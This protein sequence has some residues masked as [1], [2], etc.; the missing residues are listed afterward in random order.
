MTL[1]DLGLAPIDVLDLIADEGGAGLAELDDR[2]RAPG[3]RHR[4]PRARRRGSRS[5]TWTAGPGQTQRLRGLGAGE[6]AAR[7]WR[8]SRVRCG[9]ATSACR[10]RRR[11]RT[12]CP[13]WWRAAASPTWST[14]SRPCATD[15]DAAIA[16]GAAAARRP[17]HEPRRR[18]SPASTIGIATVVER[19]A[20]T[21]RRSA[22]PGSDGARLYDWRAERFATCSTRIADLLDRWDGRLAACDAALADELRCPARPRP[23]STSA[24]A[25]RR[26]PGLDELPPTPIRSARARPAARDAPRR[27][28]AKRTRRPRTARRRRQSRPCRPAG[29]LR[30]ASCRSPPSTPSRSP[31]PTSR[32]R[33]R[34]LGGPAVAARLGARRRRQADRRGATGADGARCRARPARRAS[35]ALQPAAEA[36]FGEGFTLIPT[37]TLPAAAGAEQT[38][39]HAA[40]HLAAPCSRTPAPRSDDDNP[41]D[42]WFYG[43]ARV[44]PK[45]RLLE[46]AIMLWDGARAGRRRARRA[47]AAAPGGRAV[48]GA[49]LPEAG[50]ARRRASDLRRASPGRLRPG[51][52]ACAA[53]CSTT[54]PRPSRR[55][56]RT[57]P[58][59]STRPASPSTSTGPARS[60]PR[61]CC[62]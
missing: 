35:L 30:R 28:R 57:S 29:A 49:R 44:R 13:T 56:S 32:T 60:R 5:A 18:C 23:R 8:C 34:L 59:R 25:R 58:A 39:A 46:D 1:A 27:V 22:A 45:V 53:C 12:P 41:L 33:P 50:R 6:A 2:V 21:S 20:E 38:A 7:H 26:G 9:P 10:A 31:S 4:R 55:W 62:C 36:I 42:T 47:A 40:L 24:A 51:G 3:R 19:L 48:A 16:A 14:T 11:R 15:L 61:R 17:G 37:F 52:P 54:G 43:A